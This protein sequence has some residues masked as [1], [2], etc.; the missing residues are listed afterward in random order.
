MPTRC[1]EQEAAI[2]TSCFREAPPLSQKSGANATRLPGNVA[3]RTYSSELAPLVTS[4]RTHGADVGLATDGDADRLG[5]VDETGRCITT[6]QAFAL[7][8]MHQ[9]DVLKNTGPIVRSITMTKHG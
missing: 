7:L 4:V 1:M 5:V 3:A 6:L 2:S 9:L 8:C